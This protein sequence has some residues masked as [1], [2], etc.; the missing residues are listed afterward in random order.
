M[1]EIRSMQSY[2]PP[3]DEAHQW[4][5][6]QNG[7]NSRTGGPEYWWAEAGRPASA[8]TSGKFYSVHLL[9]ATPEDKALIESH[10]GITFDFSDD[11]KTVSWKRVGAPSK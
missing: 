7:F 3:E 10:L 9:D 4:R 8:T 11:G 2:P 5:R 6:V 1:L